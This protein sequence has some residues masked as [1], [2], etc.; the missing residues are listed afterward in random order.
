MKKK[1]KEKNWWKSFKLNSGLMVETFTA[2]SRDKES[3]F[4]KKGKMDLLR[5][6][7]GSIEKQ[8]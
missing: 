7:D 6:K 8:V 2:F 4:G 1:K 5:S 3:C